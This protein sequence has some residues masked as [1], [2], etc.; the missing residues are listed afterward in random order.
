MKE[1]N[2]KLA[3]WLGS[4][5]VVAYAGLAGCAHRPALAPEPRVYP[6]APL[7]AE[8]RYPAPTEARGPAEET[9]E[10]AEDGAS[11]QGFSE[12]IRQYD[13]PQFLEHND[14]AFQA[15]LKLL[16][17]A[18]AG[19]VV[20][21]LTF[22]FDNGFVV[23]KLAAHL[24][25]AVRRGVEVRF[26]ADSK[27]GSI[28]GEKTIFDH[29]LNEEVYQ[30]MANCGVQVRIH[31]IVPHK[32][33]A[34]I[35]VP[36]DLIATFRKP[37]ISP[38]NRLNHRKLFWVKG[39]SDADAC[40][41][42]GGRNLG[43]HYLEWDGRKES[44]LDGDVLLCR[45][46]FEG[47]I[48]EG[49]R[50][51]VEQTEHS[52]DELWNDQEFGKSIVRPIFANPDFEFRFITL[53]T[54]GARV[55][56][57]FVSLDTE[58]GRALF[59]K[60][61]G[62]DR[63]HERDA[64]ELALVKLSPKHHV[65]IGIDS[66]EIDDKDR[67][68]LQKEG[69]AIPVAVPVGGRAAAKG[70]ALRQSWNWRFL[71][72]SWEPPAGAPRIPRTDQIRD[73][74]YKAIDRERKHIYIETGFAHI[75]EEFGRR[76]EAAMERGVKVEI[77]SN[78]LFTYTGA[79]KAI[80]LLM[81]PWLHAMSERWGVERLLKKYGPSAKDRAFEEAR[82]ILRLTSVHAGHLIHFKA[83]GFKCQDREKEAGHFEKRFFVGSHNFHPRS[84]LSD[85]EH[86]LTWVEPVDYDCM[87]AVGESRFSPDQ[88]ARA[89]AEKGTVAD[90]DQDLIDIRTRFYK[91]VGGIYS[92]A[93]APIL[94]VTGSLQQEINRALSDP[95][96]KKKMGTF[97]YYFAKGLIRF[98]LTE[99]PQPGE[100]RLKGPFQKMINMFGPLRDKLEK[101]M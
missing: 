88:I 83:A 23:R 19:S 68:A 59:R 100:P 75:D 101:F 11:E 25:Q 15:R 37:E 5:T 53:D 49:E 57:R 6:E 77:V 1:M 82:F 63:I 84:G 99:D 13:M 55:N 40:L 12:Y 65:K 44:F 42:L 18:P 2:S 74:L 22:T 96:A 33:V 30:Y 32:M 34:G 43:D 52:F 28:P 35:P 4:L 94:Q 21:V 48:R 58:E 3:R 56:G 47:Y 54:R 8:I 85:K 86:A 20:R 72:T 73:E 61:G 64:A 60:A 92:R 78:S 39:P 87:K 95:E 97:E 50:A 29:E 66:K 89:K 10:V 27:Y 38:V 26:M 76:L 93:G 16:D 31:N 91:R 7:P 41:I 71:R 9:P 17:R 45:H 81:N 80:R 69:F 46:M 70:H 98:V 62:T 24:C 36:D 51:I 14:R 79:A 90:M 67:E